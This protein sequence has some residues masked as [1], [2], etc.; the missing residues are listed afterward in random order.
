MAKPKTARRLTALMTIVR[1]PA[2]NP[3]TISPPAEF[4][5]T[6]EEAD[7]MIAR[8]FARP[9]PEAANASETAEPAPLV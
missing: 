5:A 6:D 7:D 1:G 4:D 8:G 3:E 2:A 9:A